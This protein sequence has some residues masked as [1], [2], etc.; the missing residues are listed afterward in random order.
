MNIGIIMEYNSRL[1]TSLRQVGGLF[2]YSNLPVHTRIIENIG[3][4]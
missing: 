2:L 3:I 1:L 4:I